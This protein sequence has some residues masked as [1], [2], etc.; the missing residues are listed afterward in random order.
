[1]T[2][3]EFRIVREVFEAARGKHGTERA[4]ALAL[5]GPCGHPTRTRVESLLSDAETSDGFMKTPAPLESTAMQLAESALMAE[6]DLLIGQR[7]GRYLLSR[8]IGAGGMGNVYEA[9]QDQPRRA[10][11]LKIIHPALAGRSS[12]KRFEY[13]SAVLAKLRHPGIAQVYEAGTADVEFGGRH[14]LVPFFA[15]E[16]LADARPITTFAVE[17]KLSIRERLEL[18][19]LV[20]D[21]V[22][23]GHQRGV[24]HRDLKPGNILVE[25]S[26]VPKVIDFGIARATETDGLPCTLPSHGSLSLN[27][28]TGDGQVIGT[29]AYM[30]PEQFEGDAQEVD[31]RADVYALGV[32]LFEMLAGRTPCDVAGK[33]PTEA[34][35]VVQDQVAPRL[36]SI[37]PALKGDVETIVGKAMALDRAE[38]YGSAAQLAD[39]LR[40][41]LRSDPIGARPPTAVYQ[42]RLFARRHKTLVGAAGAVAATLALATL[43][44]SALAIFATRQARAADAARTVADQGRA[45]AVR[46]A[47]FLQGALGSANPYLPMQLP[48]EVV[49]SG[50]DH[51][52]DWRQTPWRYCGK[53][54]FMATPTDILVAA[55]ARLRD[56]F[57]D[58]PESLAA[59]GT[60]VGRSLYNL[61][62]PDHGLGALTDALDAARRAYGNNHE[63]TIRAML[64]L[65]ECRSR[66]DR[67]DPEAPRALYREAVEAAKQTFGPLDRRTLE[68]MRYRAYDMHAFDVAHEEAG[69]FL[70]QAVDAATTVGRGDDDAVLRLESYGAYLYGW[71]GLIDLAEERGR[72]S[73]AAIIRTTGEASPLTAEARDQLSATLRRK[74]GARDEALLLARQ[75]AAG[76]ASIFGPESYQAMGLLHRVA[77]I[78]EDADEPAETAQIYRRLSQAYSS[79]LGHDRF[80]S[81]AM[82]QNLARI[83]YQLDQNPEERLQLATSVVESLRLTYKPD[84]RDLAVNLWFPR[85][86]IADAEMALGRP[87]GEQGAR[88]LLAETDSAAD[89]RIHTVARRV[90][91]RYR[92]AKRLIIAG[93]LDEAEMLLRDARQILA[94]ANSLE[95][96]QAHVLEEI[97]ARL[98]QARAK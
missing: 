68:T 35:R 89:P 3:A 13:E 51:W 54:G 22:H 29:L 9:Q 84:D 87:D 79:L 78:H 82:R 26:G 97:E 41:F 74:Q 24:I 56:T 72:K 10:V 20:C 76:W 70:I 23:H 55:A 61:S 1:M 34:A 17:Q 95:S 98:K 83:L 32:V 52:A 36:S 16:F 39:D 46:V 63:V 8:L 62:G 58:D 5:A 73:L 6:Q 96:R 40:R 91:V 60:V 18:L 47:E 15:M 49:A 42:M 33:S 38:R 50:F 48:P 27:H 90:V 4:A 81:Y 2:P 93:T 77:T 85:L 86:L 12:L 59:V 75:A 64:M 57:A 44:T 94:D 31:I 25:P 14:V 30:S 45:R 71:A 11:A 28:R 19:A 21:A 88:A 43:A 53:P 80:E 67:A 69:D 37:D 65:G 92:L 66:W 7:V